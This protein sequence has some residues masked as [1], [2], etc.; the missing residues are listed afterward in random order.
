MN[1]VDP[2]DLFFLENLKLK[3]ENKYKVDSGDFL[4]E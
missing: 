3:K 4:T 1:E 2:R